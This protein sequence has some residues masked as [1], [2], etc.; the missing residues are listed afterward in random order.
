MPQSGFEWVS[1]IINIKNMETNK[2]V[3]GIVG[4]VVGGALV[5]SANVQ[6]QEFEK[7]SPDE[8]RINTTVS[9]VISLEELKNNLVEAKEARA[10]EISRSAARV[11][12]FDSLISDLNYKITKAEQLGIND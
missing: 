2:I 3:A 10:T 9:V 7:A 8:L 5:F 1:L 6:G 11:A 4:A 12:E